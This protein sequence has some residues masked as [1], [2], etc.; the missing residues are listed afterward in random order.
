MSGVGCFGT[1][2]LLEEVE[3]SV[4]LF[5]S[6]PNCWICDIDSNDTTAAISNMKKKSYEY[7]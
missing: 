4:S 7:K 3:C 1:A 2:E 5:S 6:P